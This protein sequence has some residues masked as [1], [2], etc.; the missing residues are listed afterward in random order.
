MDSYL[1]LSIINTKLRDFYNNLDDLVEDLNID[2]II[3]IDK[4][5]EIGYLYNNKLNQFIIKDL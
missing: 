3:L 4:L 5:K 1:I 2:K